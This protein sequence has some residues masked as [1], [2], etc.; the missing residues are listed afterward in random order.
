[1]IPPV[2]EACERTNPRRDSVHGTRLG[3]EL[4]GL[5]E[6]HQMGH[7]LAFAF[8]VEPGQ[9]ER[10]DRRQREASRLCCPGNGRESSMRVL[11]VIHRIVHRLRR[12]NADVKALGRIQAL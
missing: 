1:M 4:K 9:V 3:S 10:L 12:D 5:G 7:Q 2:D 11:H 8:V 6:R